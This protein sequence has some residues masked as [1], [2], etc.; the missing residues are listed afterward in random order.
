MTV[1]LE[2]DQGKRGPYLLN[3]SVINTPP[4]F[5]GK[6][7]MSVLGEVYIRLKEKEVL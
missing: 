4:K 1:S 7:D 6:S 5:L 3:I 2:N